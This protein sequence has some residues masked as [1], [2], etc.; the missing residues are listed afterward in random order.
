[1]H[2]SA[3]PAIFVG[4][5]CPTYCLI[6]L[7]AGRVVAEVASV[8]GEKCRQIDLEM[9]DVFFYGRVRGLPHMLYPIN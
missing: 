7:L 2:C 1:M 6:T 9:H 8:S 3:A 4:V 5:L